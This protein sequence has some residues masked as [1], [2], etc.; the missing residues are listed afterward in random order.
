MQIASAKLTDGNT[1]IVKIAGEVG[2]GS[3]MAFSRAFKRAVGMSP[4]L[5]RERRAAGAA[6]NLR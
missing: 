2:Y 5:W 6:V 4:S 3:E 1:P